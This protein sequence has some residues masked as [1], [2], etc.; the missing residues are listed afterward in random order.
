MAM[1]GAADASP[2]SKTCLTLTKSRTN[3]GPICETA[4]RGI[5]LKPRATPGTPCAA[6]VRELLSHSE[7]GP[8][9]HNVTGLNREGAEHLIHSLSRRTIHCAENQLP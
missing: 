6:S 8:L 4:P 5:S 9:H 3:S 1:H 7:S 2:F